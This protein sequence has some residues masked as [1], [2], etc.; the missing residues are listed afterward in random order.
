MDTDSSSAPQPRPQKVLIIGGGPCGL[1]TLRNFLQSNAQP[2]DDGGRDSEQQTLDVELVERRDE[3]GGVWF[4]SDETY[5][6]ERSLPPSSVQGKWPISGGPSSSSSTRPHWPSPAYRDLK[7]NVYPSF[8]EFSDAPFPPPANGEP[9]PT[10]AETHAYLLRFA[11]PLR[12]RIRLNTEVVKVEEQVAP[13]SGAGAG[14]VMGAGEGQYGGWE[15]TLREWDPALGVQMGRR[16]TKRYDAVIVAAGW[17]DTPLYPATE[18]I[19]LAKEMGF[20]HH[21]KWYR[22]TS[23]YE[24]KRV[25]V[26]G[27]K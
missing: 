16:V 11:E 9:F 3:V 15:V 26:V 27:N 10:L 4:W 14:A 21:A 6:L 17:Y 25:V 23:W 1:V 7:G 13:G 24:G 5:Q 12:S 22:D 20:V 8:L 2:S 19:E 18:G